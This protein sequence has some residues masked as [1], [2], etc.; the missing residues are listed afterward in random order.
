VILIVSIIVFLAHAMV[1]ILVRVI[2]TVIIIAG[3]LIYA[4]LKVKEKEI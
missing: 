3:I 4:T 1:P 2:I